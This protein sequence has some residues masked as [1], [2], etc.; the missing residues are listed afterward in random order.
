MNKL[1]VVPQRIFDA[2]NKQSNIGDKIAGALI[3]LCPLLQHYKGPVDNAATTVL[4]IVAFYMMFRIIPQLKTITFKALRPV[5]ILIIFFV[6]KLFAHGTNLSEI[7]QVGL[8]VFLLLAYALKCV[9]VKFLIKFAT[10]V[11][12]LAGAIMLLQYLCFYIFKFHIQCVPTDLLL[13]EG[14]KWIWGAQTGLG[15]ITGK[16]GTLYRPSAFFLE[17]SHLYLYCFPFLMLSLFWGNKDN[18]SLVIPGLIAAGMILCT[19]GMGIAAAVFA[20][21]LFCVTVDWR[22]RTFHLANIKKKRNLMLLGA[23]V[24]IFILAVLF[25]PFIQRSVLRIFYNPE[26]STA[27]SGRTKKASELIASMSFSGWITGYTDLIQAKF[28]VP[29]VHAMLY[30]YGLPGL[31]LSSWVY[32][33]GLFTQRL[34]FFL[35]TATI[36]ITSFFSAHTHGT[37]YMLFYVLILLY[38]ESKTHKPMLQEPLQAAGCFVKKYTSKIKIK[39]N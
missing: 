34:P 33:R 24:V 1:A 28:N 26:S 4:L 2:V 9:N 27:V 37:F 16:V 23:V 5:L 12:A 7:G 10:W 14:K 20:V 3:A 29:G 30:K 31:I 21:G 18:R 6:L 38:G 22:E 13:K 17:P 8:F 25:I 32:L 11:A 19:S 15:G 36:V 35:V 39:T